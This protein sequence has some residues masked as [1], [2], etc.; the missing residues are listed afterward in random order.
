MLGAALAGLSLVST[1]A[2]AAVYIEST[3]FGDNFLIRTDLRSTFAN[4]L[5][6]HG[7]FGSLTLPAIGGGDRADWIEVNVAPSIMANINF[8][9]SST[10]ANPFFGLFAYDTSGNQLSNG[11]LFVMPDAGT[12]YEGALA[13]FLTPE[14]GIIILSTS[15][16]AGGDATINYSI[17]TV[18]EPTSAILGVAGLAAA[19]LRRRRN[20]K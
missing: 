11:Y 17:G 7:I 19:A 6:N 4:F 10:I 9:A 13:P 16:E 12:T 1:D 2:E 15:N 8:R 14:N 5:D 3:D 18:P 20:E